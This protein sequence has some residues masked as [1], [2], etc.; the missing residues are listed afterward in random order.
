MQKVTLYTKLDCSLCDKAYQMLLDLAFDMPLEIDIID[1]SHPHNNLETRY[2]TR[3]P[4]IAHDQVETEL[5]W[6]FTPTSIKLYL[7]Q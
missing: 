7:S 6:P 2:G 3:I 5:E 4:V 1:I